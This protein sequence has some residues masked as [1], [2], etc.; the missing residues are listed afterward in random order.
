MSEQTANA[1][2]ALL[3]AL[4]ELADRSE[5]YLEKVD[6]DMA[7]K[8]ADM[9]KAF[10]AAKNLH[11]DIKKQLTRLYHVV[12]AF[13]KALLPKLFEHHG[14]DMVRIP[15]LGRS[16]SVRQM[17]TATMIDKEGAI[18]WLRGEGHGDLVQETVNAGTL[19]SFVRN[20]VLEMGMDPPED[21]IKVTN[22]TTIASNKYNPK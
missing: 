8:P 13:D 5:R 20:M 1:N 11:D 17:T 12:N 10:W 21:L 16:F 2:E 3:Q 7:L 4:T 9:A 22:Y 15:E 6:G 19:A 14:V 18:A